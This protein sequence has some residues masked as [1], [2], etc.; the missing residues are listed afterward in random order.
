MAL[1]AIHSWRWAAAA[2][3]FEKRR[4]SAILIRSLGSVRRSDP[5]WLSHHR[6]ASGNARIYQ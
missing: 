2:A 3:A 4:Y 1:L 6:G 5:R